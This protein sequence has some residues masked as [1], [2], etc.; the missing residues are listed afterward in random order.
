MYTTVNQRKAPEQL[1][2]IGKVHTQ[3]YKGLQVD[4]FDIKILQKN[5]LCGK[6]ATGRQ[7]GTK[8][9]IF[10]GQMELSSQVI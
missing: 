6:V 10:P 2:C 4:P 8:S 5:G 9:Q 1:V 3:V 7:N